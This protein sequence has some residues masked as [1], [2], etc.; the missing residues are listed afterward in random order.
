MTYRLKPLALLSLLFAA[1]VSCTMEARADTVTLTGGTVVTDLLTPQAHI[2]GVSGSNFFLNA[3]TVSSYTS[4]TCTNA[5]PCAPGQTVNWVRT[6]SVTGM[7]GPATATLNGTQYTNLALQ[8]SVLNFAAG[9]FTL[10]DLAPS[11]TL[12]SYE[13]TVPFTVSG[14]IIA[15]GFVN[16]QSDGNTLFTVDVTGGGL[17]T[18][19]VLQSGSSVFITSA[20]FNFQPQPTPEPATLLLLGTGIAGLAAR[21]R[22]RRSRG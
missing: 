9:P 16:G 6:I 4:N 21:T 22:R 10:E 12:Q 1:L 5:Q 20:T 7:S 13:V 15:S 2:Q 14:T 19:R 17:A 18:L 8:G 3:P 11:S